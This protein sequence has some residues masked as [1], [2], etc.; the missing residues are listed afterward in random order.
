MS[1]SL[2]T[3][4]CS[5]I[6]RKQSP[7]VALQQRRERMHPQSTDDWALRL[8]SCRAASL[9]CLRKMKI[10]SIPVDKPH[11]RIPRFISDTKPSLQRALNLLPLLCV[12]SAQLPQKLGR[13]NSQ[14]ALE[15]ERPWLEPR[16]F[17]ANLE[18]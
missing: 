4:A 8:H 10:A 7:G 12:E 2:G 1:L 9:V 18:S 5:S 3:V 13:G 16:H 17:N 15:I 6:P 14:H 11:T